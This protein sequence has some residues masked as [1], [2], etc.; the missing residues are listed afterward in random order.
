MKTEFGNQIH[1]LAPCAERFVETLQECV[2][3]QIDSL[4]EDREAQIQFNWSTPYDSPQVY[5]S[6]SSL[7]GFSTC[8]LVLYA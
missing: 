7:R 3:N 1:Q 8:S 5:Y 2:A 6:G 4:K